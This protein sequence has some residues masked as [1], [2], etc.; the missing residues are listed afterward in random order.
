[1][2]FSRYLIPLFAVAVLVVPG[3]LLLLAL[4]VRSRLYVAGLT[5]PVTVGFSMV[6]ASVLNAVGIPF[7]TWTMFGTVVVVAAATFVVR[8]RLLRPGPLPDDRPAPRAAQRAPALPLLSDSVSK[9][10]QLLG[11]VLL[12]GAFVI[13]FATWMDGIGPWTTYNQDHDTIMHYLLTSYIQRTGDAAPWLVMPNDLLTGDNVSFYPDGLHM[14]SALVGGPVGNAVIGLNAVVAAWFAV[15]WPLS[16]AALAAAATRQFITDRGWTL[17]AAG[18]AGIVAVGIYRPAFNL[19]RDNGLIPNAAAMVLVPGIAAAIIVLRRHEW[20]AVIGVALAVAGVLITHPSSAASLGVTVV[21]LAVV[22]GLTTGGWAWIRSRWSTWLIG[23][24]AAVVAA[25]P[26]LVMVTQVASSVG[27]FPAAAQGTPPTE[28]ASYVIPLV[29]GGFFDPAPYT[30]QMWATVLLL[31]GVVTTLVLRR[32][33]GVL[34]AWGAWVVI[35]IGAMWD[36]TTFP[37]SVIGAFFYNS[38]ARIWGNVGLYAPA[39]AAIGILGVGALA[40]TVVRRFRRVAATAGAV[41]VA[42]AAVLIVGYA[43]VPGWSYR[44]TNATALADR[45]SQPQFYRVDAADKAAARWLSNHVDPGERVMNTANDGSTYA[46]VR[47]GVPLVNIDTLGTA[48]VPYT[49]RL[50]TNFNHA[51]QSERICQWVKQLNI[52]YVYDDNKA[53]S[54]GS[55]GA[56]HNWA[57]G[58]LVSTPPGL[59]NLDD[60]P[61]LTRVFHQ[62]SVSVYKVESAQLGCTVTHSSNRST[63]S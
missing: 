45:W 58:E 10:A 33:M 4:G 14:V 38:A 63:D 55:A 56:P 60:K 17:L 43:A 30:T 50:L 24:G 8:Y 52:T 21:V 15:A 12:L 2:D 29:Y 44:N 51:A 26:M 62:G 16:A 40:A 49:W 9:A 3:L 11:V 18:A 28:S 7:N 19:V 23:A 27:G 54:I 46:Y 20:S 37:L 1:M 61:W 25:L 35:T 31:I 34:L 13:G 32:G 57:N 48:E 59:D 22:R 36:V 41:A 53:P 39:L 47:Y 5:V 42:L 6:T